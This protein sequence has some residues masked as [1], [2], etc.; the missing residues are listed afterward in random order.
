MN[1]SSANQELL[2][3]GT[4]NMDL[5]A[6]VDRMPSIGETLASRFT[7]S[8]AGGKALNQAVAASRLHANT[9]FIG[10]IGKDFFGTNIKETL[11][12]ENINLCDLIVDPRLETG[13]SFIIVNGS[14]DNTII[15][16][17]NANQSISTDEIDNVLSDLKYVEIASLQLEMPIKTRE[18]IIKKLHDARIKTILNAAPVVEM[19]N[20][21]L[22]MIDV[23]IVN[24]V[25]AG[26]MLGKNMKTIENVTKHIR[27]LKRRDN[28]KIIV[29]LGS[30]GCIFADGEQVDHISAPQVEVINTTGAGDCFCGSFAA[31]WMDHSFSE[32]VEYAVY[33]SALSVT[34]HGA[35]ESMPY[36]EEVNT[37]FNNKEAKEG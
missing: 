9:R 5:F 14:G 32:A 36:L 31:R 25:E 16:N 33:A 3:C 21:S 26:Q 34:K 11:M 13:T 6:Y 29:T 20:Q 30:Q 19:S 22:S 18:E 28:Q 7:M 1:I 27:D 10:K 37:F 17:L 12:R 2:V 8:T 4:I 23:L 15:T 24:E 35:V